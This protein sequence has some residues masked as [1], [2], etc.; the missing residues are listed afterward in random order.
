MRK[1]REWREV[2]Y[3]ELMI[4]GF[5]SA[6][7]LVVADWLAPETRVRGVGLLIGMV[8]CTAWVV[9]TFRRLVV[10]TWKAGGRAEQRR[11]ELEAAAA[12]SL[13]VVHEMTPR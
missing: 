5:V 7:V 8:A 9:R 3:Q 12:P 10:P 2:I 4:L 1:L 11:A 6:G 13:A